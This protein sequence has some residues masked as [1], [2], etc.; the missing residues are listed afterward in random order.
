MYLNVITLDLFLTYSQIVLGRGAAC[1]MLIN[2]V[3]VVSQCEAVTEILDGEVPRISGCKLPSLHLMT[4]HRSA[5][6]GQR[7][8][9]DSAS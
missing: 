3:V 2:S 4:S 5:A 8:R 9:R 6:I 7:H 1:K